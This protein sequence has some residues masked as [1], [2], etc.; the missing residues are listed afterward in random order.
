[1]PMRY[2]NKILRNFNNL[3]KLYNYR[4]V[5]YPAGVIKIDIEPYSARCA[6][7]PSAE[8]VMTSPLGTGDFRS[9]R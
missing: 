1:M 9:A 8:Q 6:L 5:P 3:I 7:R 2:Q 4:P